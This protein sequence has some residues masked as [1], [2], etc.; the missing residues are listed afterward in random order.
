[1][2]E[3][4]NKRKIDDEESL[5]DSGS[6][7]S[8]YKKYSKA[9]EGTTYDLYLRH[10][11]N[12]YSLDY[13]DLLHDLASFSENDKVYLHLDNNGGDADMGLRVARAIKQCKAATIIRVENH[14]YSAAAIIALSGNMLQMQPGTFI[15]FH[16]WSGAFIG[17][18]GEVRK[19]HDEWDSAFWSQCKDIVCPFLTQ[20]EIKLLQNDTDIYIHA[21]SMKSFSTEQKKKNEALLKDLQKRSLRH[22][23]LLRELNKDA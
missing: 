7:S 11:V 12:G 3:Q 6:S 16:N 23:P 15:M 4:D 9:S 1:M 5:D 13:T 17:K 22:F 2:Q 21:P 8:L 18:G 20:K 19:H 10:E 14:C